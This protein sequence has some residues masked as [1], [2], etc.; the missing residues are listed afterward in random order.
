MSDT[1]PHES[2][3]RELER[4]SPE[5]EGPSE[6]TVRRELRVLIPIALIGAIGGGYAL[7]ALG[8]WPALGIGFALTAV[9]YMLAWW[10]EIIAARGR[11]REHERLERQVA[12]DES[13]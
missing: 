11:R 5:G 6:R 10:P 1:S 13:R 4:H 9:Y 3:L 7:H 2:R 12:R 8:G